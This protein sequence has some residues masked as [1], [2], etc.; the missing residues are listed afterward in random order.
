[1]R[2]GARA[3]FAGAEEAGRVADRAA[4]E[5][6]ADAAIPE[7]AEDLAARAARDGARDAV[8]AV[9]LGIGAGDRLAREARG[10]A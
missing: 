2:E 5:R 7:V 6:N 3:L 1:M 10:P 4:A 8:A 9:R